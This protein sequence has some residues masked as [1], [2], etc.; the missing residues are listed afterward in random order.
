MTYLRKNLIV[1]SVLFM[2]LLTIFGGSSNV[3]ALENNSVTPRAI[4]SY[5]KEYVVGC[6]EIGYSRVKLTIK[7]N[8]TT[9]KKMVYSK[10]YDTH[11]DKQWFNVQVSKV[12]TTPAV[13]SVIK[14]NT[15]KVEVTAYQFGLQSVTGNGTI[16]L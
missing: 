5:T 4:E 2:M 3:N 8:M 15:I 12:K 10:D 14:G 6:G 11:F 16:Y 9:G 1:L 7:H 13:G